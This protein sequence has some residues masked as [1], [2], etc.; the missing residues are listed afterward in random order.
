MSANIPD[1][2]RQALSDA[3]IDRL[4]GFLSGLK[5]S[6]ALTFEG[7]DGFFCALIAGP[8][9]V[10]PTEY[11]PILWG[12]ELPDENAFASLEDANATLQLVMRHW[13]SIISE[14]ETDGVYGPAIDDPDEHGVPGRRWARGFMRGVALRKSS[15]TELFTSDNEGQLLSIPLVAGEVDPQWPAEPL[16]DEKREQLVMWMAA[17]VARSYRH[18]QARRRAA[19]QAAGQEQTYRRETPK[20]GRNDPCPCRS[21]RKFKHCCGGS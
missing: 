14:L 11:L 16:S 6:D 9:T 20:I 18:F 5:N 2:G 21:G 19:A 13:N 10:M 4:S 8:D 17:G 3:E 12:G 7:M 1:P 15:W